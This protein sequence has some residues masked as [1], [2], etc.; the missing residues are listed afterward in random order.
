MSADAHLP[1]FAKPVSWL[2]DSQCSDRSSG[3]GD[4][5]VL[6]VLGHQKRLITRNTVAMVQYLRRR[7]WAA[8]STP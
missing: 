1:T 7:S 2:H 4:W 8:I 6:L 5:L 3:R